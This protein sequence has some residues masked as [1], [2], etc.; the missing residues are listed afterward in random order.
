MN[1]DTPTLQEITE[2]MDFL[3]NEKWRLLTI[4]LV[5]IDLDK[6]HEYAKEKDLA[7]IFYHYDNGTK[8]AFED[9]EGCLKHIMCI[10]IYLNDNHEGWLLEDLET[11]LANPE[12]YAKL[13]IAVKQLKEGENNEDI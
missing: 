5:F 10:D 3:S 6:F 8:I 13:W 1:N 7:I 12:I 9:K 2:Y 11:N 4:P